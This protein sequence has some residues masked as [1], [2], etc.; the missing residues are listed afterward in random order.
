MRI[1]KVF[2]SLFNMKEEGNNVLLVQKRNPSGSSGEEN[3]FIQVQL[4]IKTT[5][6]CVFH[7]STVFLKIFIFL[8]WVSYL[9]F[10]LIQTEMEN[11][12]VEKEELSRKE[13]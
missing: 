9:K 2:C 4:H 13:I 8:K 12:T 7:K 3:N 11:L 10:Y 6:F 1:E 5:Y